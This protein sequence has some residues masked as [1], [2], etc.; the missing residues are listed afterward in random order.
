MAELREIGG[1]IDAGRSLMIDQ[2][3]C[4]YDCRRDVS[5]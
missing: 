5:K 3:R 2:V 4:S 1:E